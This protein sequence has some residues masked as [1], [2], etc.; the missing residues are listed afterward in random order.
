MEE[1]KS[2]KVK[3]SI[4]HKRKRGPVPSAASTG[5]ASAKSGKTAKSSSGGISASIRN[6]WKKNVPSY[7]QKAP[8]KK[9][10]LDFAI[11]SA[12]VFV[13]YKFGSSINQALVDYV[14]SEAGLRKQMAE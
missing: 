14:P 4:T 10:M 2:S 13:I 11:F 3:A 12:G 1:S 7:M 9:M 8:P 6:A 5:G